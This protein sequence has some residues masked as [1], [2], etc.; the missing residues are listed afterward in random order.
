MAGC[1][2]ASNGDAESTHANTDTMKLE[3]R[4]AKG[5]SAERVRLDLS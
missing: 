3:A 4:G 5:P 2:L 1:Q